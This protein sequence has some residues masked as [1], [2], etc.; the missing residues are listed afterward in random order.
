[1]DLP[2]A[3]DNMMTF[4]PGKHISYPNFLDF[5]TLALAIFIWKQHNY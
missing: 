2:L 4:I 1:M 3:A 5:R